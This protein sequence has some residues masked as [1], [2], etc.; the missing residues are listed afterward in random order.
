MN[1]NLSI[2]DIARMAGV[3]IATVSRVINKNGKVAKETEDKILKVMEEN[4]YV[5]NLLAKGIRTR[6]ST[7][8]GIVVPD[9]SNEFFSKIAQKIQMLFFKKGYATIICNTN[10]DYK[11]ENQCLDML[12]AQQVGGIIHIVS[13]TR[14]KEKYVPMP[15][16]YID[17]EPMYLKNKDAVVVE[18]DNMSGGYQATREMIE[19]GCRNILCLS[20]KHNVS[21]HK[22][23]YLG[24]LKAIDEA[25]LQSGLVYADSISMKDGY[26]QTK[27]YFKEHT[28]TDGVF[29][30]TDIIAIGAMKALKEL[31]IEVPQDVKVF[32]YDDSEV[33][34]ISTKTLSTVRQPVDEM[35]KIAVA[36]L[37]KLMNEVE[38]SNKK[39]VLPVEIIKRE[40]T[41]VN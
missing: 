23:R 18:S 40:T 6:K 4:K 22:K 15:T 11:L 37:E 31:N 3:S 38:V 25:G 2:K 35:V 10:E 20:P 36:N 34:L 7:I 1:N 24:Y 39:T 41:A 29:A 14:K 21:T 13:S 33:S 19:N 16:V 28:K 5:P 30:T 27:K 17:R 12:Q 9:I 32:G 8:V 26:L